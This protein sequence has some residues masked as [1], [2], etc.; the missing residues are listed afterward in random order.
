VV[1]ALIRAGPLSEEVGV[2]RTRIAAVYEGFVW[3]GEYG[4][5]MMVLRRKLE[6]QELPVAAVGSFL[7]QHL[8]NGQH[9][10]VTSTGA[11]E[12]W[13]QA[14][15]QKE[16]QIEHSYDGRRLKT[17]DQ[18]ERRKHFVLRMSQFQSQHPRFSRYH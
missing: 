4:G 5:R 7:E 15:L 14:W 6:Q 1:L 8:C 12:K 2:A 16:K 18:R 10:K 17:H 13:Q 3:L 9:L 11:V